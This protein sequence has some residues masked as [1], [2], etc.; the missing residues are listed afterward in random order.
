[1][2]TAPR[3]RSTVLTPS[4]REAWATWISGTTWQA[5]LTMTSEGRTH[6]EALLKR[7]RYCT[8]IANDAIYGRRWERRDQGCQWVAGVERHQSGWPHLHAVLRFPEFD[9]AGDQGR[10]FFPI[11][12]WQERFT[13][14]GGICRLDI[15]R[16]SEATVAYV[17]KYVVKD[18][19]LHWSPQVAFASPAGTQLTL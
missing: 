1:M 3:L 17:T 12:P 19:E 9:L 5:F 11:A 6:P 4:N 7:F 15:A 18:G 16:S 10:E 2:A 8:H 13:Q 14:T